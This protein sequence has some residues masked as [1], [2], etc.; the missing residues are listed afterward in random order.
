[1]VVIFLGIIGASK[2]FRQ[3]EN[4]MH[5]LYLSLTREKL[6]IDSTFRG[7]IG[8]KL[9]GV[10]GTY[11]GSNEGSNVGSSV[12]SRLDGVAGT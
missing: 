2:A 6:A 11:I 5:H 3:T 10:V 12:G 1:M 7:I 8:S 9:G 4:I